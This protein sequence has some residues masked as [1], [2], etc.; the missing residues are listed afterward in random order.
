MGA[1]GSHEVR[2]ARRRPPH[3]VAGRRWP[4][5]SGVSWLVSTRM[6][7]AAGVVTVGRLGPL[8]VSGSSSLSGSAPAARAGDS[9][10][11][12]GDTSTAAVVDDPDGQGPVPEP[13][14]ST[15]SSPASVSPPSSAL[16][17]VLLTAAQELDPTTAA[18]C[19][20]ASADPERAHPTFSLA[21]AALAE[22]HWSALTPVSPLRRW[23]IVEL[24]DDTRLT[25][26]RLRL[27]E[28][29]LHF[30][31]ARPTWTPGCTARRAAPRYRTGCRRR[32]TWPRAGCWR[33]GRTAPGRTRRCSSSW[34]AATCVAAPTSPPRVPHAPDSACTR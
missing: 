16:T 17:L 18:R 30:L 1:H 31:P 28:R 32:T 34:S 12:S 10:G 33:A 8:R 4:T 19:A 22:P 15:P 9:G 5:R 13:L 29:I 14:P 23:R 2:A 25:T 21:L 20:A 24:D 6:R 27:D 3:T 11:A 7:G 26:S